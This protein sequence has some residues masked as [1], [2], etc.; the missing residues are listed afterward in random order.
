MN[1]L[2]ILGQAA[3]SVVEDPLGGDNIRHHLALGRATEKAVTTNSAVGDPG[4]DYMITHGQCGDTVTDCVNNSGPFVPHHEGHRHIPFAPNNVE[5][6]VTDTRGGYSDSNLST[7]WIGQV[8]IGYQHVR[9]VECN[10]LH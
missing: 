1:N 8:D 10:C 4:Q 3:R 2:A 9:A 5:V 7:A 6:G